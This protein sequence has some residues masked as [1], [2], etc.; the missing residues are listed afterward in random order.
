M[1][2]SEGNGGWVEVE[3][4]DLG[5]P[6]RTY[7]RLSD[8]DGIDRVTEIYID[9][10]GEAIQPGAIRR[11]PLAVLEQWLSTWSSKARRGVAG[12]DLSRLASHFGTTWGDRQA[13]IHNWVALSWFAQYPKS[14]IRQPR[15]GDRSRNAAPTEL[16]LPP[17]RLQAPEAG[18]TD[19]FLSDVGKAYDAAIAR[20]LPPAVTIADLAGVTKKTAQSWI[21]KARKRGLMLPAKS[22]GRIV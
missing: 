7:V 18:L 1:R 15:M 9:G 12:P 3:D 6:G 5:L 14:D 11:F 17:L 20:G 4:D 10:R 21:Y 16:V 2:A 22:K 13:T 19:G 8:V